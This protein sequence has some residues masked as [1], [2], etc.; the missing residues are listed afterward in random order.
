MTVQSSCLR[1]LVLYCP[2][3]LHRMASPPNCSLL[4]FLILWRAESPTQV[5]LLY[6]ET[7]YHWGNPLHHETK[8]I[9]NTV[10]P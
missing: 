1:L 9:V 10:K 8:Q 4:G 7:K 6:V 2:P 3:S 5:G